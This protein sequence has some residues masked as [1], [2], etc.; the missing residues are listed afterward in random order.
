M[1]IADDLILCRT[2]GACSLR[3]NPLSWI[4]RLD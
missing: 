2:E 4:L 1:V 3:G